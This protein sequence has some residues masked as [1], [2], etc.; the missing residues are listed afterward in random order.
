MHD[1]C[2]TIAHCQL[3]A[4]LQCLFNII[5]FSIFLLS[6]TNLSHCKR[7]ILLYDYV[8]DICE[9][10]TMLTVGLFLGRSIF[11]ARTYKAPPTT[12]YA[13]ALLYVYVCVQKISL[14]LASILIT[15]TAREAPWYNK[16]RKFFC[17]LRLFF[18]RKFKILS[19][20]YS[21]CAPPPGVEKIFL[22]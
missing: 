18:Y 3:Y 16:E 10:L 13:D 6:F 9:L 2:D 4:L 21:K 8:F 17:R 5:S 7:K 19:R 15:T 14:N 20:N 22:E 1:P 12:R 11:L